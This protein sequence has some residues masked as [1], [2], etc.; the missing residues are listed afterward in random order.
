M[1]M[2]MHST[3]GLYDVWLNCDG[4]G[5][6]FIVLTAVPEDRSFLALVQVQVV[7]DKDLDALD[8]ILSS[9]IVS[10]DLQ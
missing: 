8:R 7:S 2:K 9:F 5:T 6:S 4:T 1:I 10:G 3:R